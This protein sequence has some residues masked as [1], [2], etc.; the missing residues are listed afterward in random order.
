[1]LLWSL[2]Q[3]QETGNLSK[4]KDINF[5]LNFNFALIKMLLLA[6]F[7]SLF[8]PKGLSF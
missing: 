1:M 4:I 3:V 2:T 8:I 5:A 6:A 7:Y